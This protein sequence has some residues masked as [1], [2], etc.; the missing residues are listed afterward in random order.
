M[1]P[2]TYN[3]NYELLL[4]IVSSNYVAGCSAHVAYSF[5]PGC[6]SRGPWLANQGEWMWSLVSLLEVPACCSVVPGFSGLGVVFECFLVRVGRSN[7][8]FFLCES[9]FIWG[10]KQ[11]TPLF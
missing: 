6:V 7:P 3:V 5:A 2:I 11:E 10:L 9:W 1:N 8:P 4:K